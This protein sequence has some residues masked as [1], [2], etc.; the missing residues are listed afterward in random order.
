MQSLRGPVPPAG[1]SIAHI[2]EKVVVRRGRASAQERRERKEGEGEGERK[3]GRGI[4]KR[5]YMG[6]WVGV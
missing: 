6:G 4:E 2:R 5:E 1:K 3:K